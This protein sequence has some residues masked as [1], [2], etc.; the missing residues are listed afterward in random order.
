MNKTKLTGSS[1]Y[2]FR[3]ASNFNFAEYE[4][5]EGIEMQ[6]LKAR[7]EYKSARKRIEL[8]GQK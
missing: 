2:P 6:Q 5:Q 7:M 1:K 8:Q 4:R 3:N